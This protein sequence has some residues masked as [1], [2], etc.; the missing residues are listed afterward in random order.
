MVELKD[1]MK[2]NNIKDKLLINFNKALKDEELDYLMKNY[3][4]I[5]QFWKNLNVNGAIAKIVNQY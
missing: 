2:K 5:L 4:N 1:M 3:L